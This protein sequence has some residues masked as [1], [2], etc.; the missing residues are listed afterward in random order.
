M[1]AKIETNGSNISVIDIFSKII[2][3]VFATNPLCERM[4]IHI[5]HKIY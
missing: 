4:D 3:I 5:I 1:I 2:I